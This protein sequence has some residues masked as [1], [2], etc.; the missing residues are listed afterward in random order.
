MNAPT[1]ADI[2]RATILTWPARVTEEHDGW[3]HLA[4]NGVTGRVN[5]V[6]PVSLPVGDIERAMHPR[7]A[8]FLGL[9]L[10]TA[11]ADC[12]RGSSLRMA[13]PRQGISLSGFSGAVIPKRR[14]R[15]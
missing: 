3:F 15:L 5:A 11:R 10:G 12:R 9:R 6:W 13:P 1:A 4:D 7:H 14:P 2:D 8:R